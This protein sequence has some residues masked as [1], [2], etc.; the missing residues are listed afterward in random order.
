MGA[1]VRASL[2]NAKH[3]ASPDIDPGGGTATTYALELWC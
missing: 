3:P 2:V 1:R